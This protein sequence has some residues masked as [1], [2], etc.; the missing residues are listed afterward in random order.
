MTIKAKIESV[1]RYNITIGEKTFED[2]ELVSEWNGLGKLN[3]PQGVLIVD[4][5]SKAEEILNGVM[6]EPLEVNVVKASVDLI[7]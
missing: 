5:P 6:Q 2:F 3:G 4:M 7:N 1:K